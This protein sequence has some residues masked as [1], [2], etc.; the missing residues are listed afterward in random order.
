V[1]P[2]DLRRAAP[3]EAALAHDPEYVARVE[4]ECLAGQR[5]LSGG[6]TAIGRDSYRV[7][8]QAVGG[9][10]EAVD[11]VL[12]GRAANAFCAVRPPGHHA[13]SRRGM[14]FCL[15]NNAAIAASHARLR[16][17][18]ERVLIAD[19]DVHHG[20]GTQEIFWRDGSVLFMSSHQWPLYPGSGRADEAGEGP[21]RGCII[22][23]PL[24]P[25]SGDE[26]FIAAFRDGLEP[27][28]RRF[29]PQL[30]IV[31]A[32]FDCRAGDPLAG[33]QVSDEGLRAV[34]RILLAIAREHAGG[35]LVSILEGGYSLDGLA[36]AARIHVDELA[37]A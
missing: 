2:S 4:R 7:A 15:F 33:L 18:V 26:P 16:R 5:E 17:G 32:G 6:D 34:A 11:A 35:K 14:G 9:V 20:N 13:S 30:V 12:A 29:R 23:V 3:D 25:G 19:F 10:L 37:L 1:C 22:N 24:P 21:G 28:A 8:L 27:A 31:S 36:A